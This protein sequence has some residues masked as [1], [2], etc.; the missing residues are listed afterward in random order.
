MHNTQPSGSQSVTHNIGSKDNDV[1][2]DQLHFQISEKIREKVF[3]RARMLLRM[4]DLKNYYLYRHTDSTA[5]KMDIL[6]HLH[7]ALDNFSF[8]NKPHKGRAIKSC[9]TEE[10]LDNKLRAELKLISIGYI[11]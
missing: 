9:T 3:E 10:E 2:N 5:K 11:L 4:N 6:N 1:D 8:A 7:L